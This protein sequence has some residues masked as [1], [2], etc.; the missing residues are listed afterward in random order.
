MELSS[1]HM[2]T[3]TVRFGYSLLYSLFIGYGLE[4]GSSLYTAIDPGIPSDFATCNN[5]VSEW[6][7]IPLFPIVAIATGMT[8]GARV[9]QWPSVTICACLAMTV[10]YFASKVIVESQIVATIGA[11]SIGLFGNIYYRL[12]GELT[13]VP[14]CSGMV[15][16][17]TGNIGVKGAFLLIQ[18]NNDGGTFA[19]EMVLGSLGIAVGLFAAALLPTFPKHKHRSINLSF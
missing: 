2:I 14:L 5:P 6:V 17:T 18:E 4:I 15:L 16:L 10:A 9:R 7:Y 8:F 13:L 1:Q 12:T 19:M 11:F 3:G